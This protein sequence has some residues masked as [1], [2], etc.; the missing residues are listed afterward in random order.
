[1]RHDLHQ[2]RILTGMAT[3]PKGRAKDSKPSTGEQTVV[4]ETQEVGTSRHFHQ[5]L[6]GT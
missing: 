3:K 6:I 1:M 4:V 5:M 2:P